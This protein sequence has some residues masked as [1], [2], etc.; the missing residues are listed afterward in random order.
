MHVQGVKDERGVHR[1][2]EVPDE[3]FTG[4]GGASE[5]VELQDKILLLRSK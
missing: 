4:F 3:N 1:H 2:K 5:R